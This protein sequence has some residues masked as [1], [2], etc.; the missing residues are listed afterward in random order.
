MMCKL[1]QRL[2]LN[3]DEPFVYYIVHSLI[4]LY[5]SFWL[6]TAARLGSVWL[7]ILAQSA[8]G[9]NANYLTIVIQRLHLLGIPQLLSHSP[10]VGHTPSP[11]HIL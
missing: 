8:P 7:D 5:Q 4:D 1:C 10:M 11:K 2:I 3:D 9:R 6:I